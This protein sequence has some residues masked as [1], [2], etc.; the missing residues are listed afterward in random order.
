[1]KKIISVILTLAVL[2]GT[3]AVGSVA[4]SDTCIKLS[5]TSGSTGYSA[6]TGAVNTYA[7]KNG[8]ATL[9]FDVKL[10]SVATPPSGMT[11][12]LFAFSGASDYNYA[13]FD[14]TNGAFKAGEGTA[15]PTDSH[16]EGFTAY[17][18]RSFD[19]KVGQWYE[20]AYQFDGNNVTVYAD[21]MPM[22][23]AEVASSFETEYLILYP[24]YCTVL[25]DNLRVCSKDYNVRD[26]YGDVYA[27]TDFTGVTSA[28][29]A[30]CWSFEGTGYSVSTA[31][32]TMPELVD[33][34]PARTVSPEI[35]GS[36]LTYAEAGGSGA[37]STGVSFAAYNG[38]TVVEDIRVDRKSPLGNFSVR[39]GGNYIAGYDFDSARFLISQRSGYSFSSNSDYTYAEMPYTI[40]LKD[41]NE[42]AVRQYGETVSVYLNG[43]LMVQASNP[44]FAAGYDTVDVSCY[45]IGAA[46]DNMVVA[47]PDYNV[48]EAQ[49]SAAAKF[50]FDENTDYINGIWN[51]ALG[52][53]T[54]GYSIKRNADALT[55]VV[56]TVTADAG[57]ANMAISLAGC[58]GV[59]GFELSVTYP[60][61]ITVASVSTASRLTGS[62]AMSQTTANPLVMTYADVIGNTVTDGSVLNIVFNTP[63]EQ[64]NYTITAT[65]TPYFGDVPGAPVSASGK[66]TVPEPGLPTGYPDGVTYDGE[67]IS[68]NPV[69]GAIAY[70]VCFLYPYEDY[71]YPVDI[72]EDCEFPFYADEFIT[73]EG[74]SIIR[75]Y[76]YDETYER[77]GVSEDFKVLLNYDGTMHFGLKDYADN[78][79]NLLS[80]YVE[81][82]TYSADNL[83]TVN[84][85]LAEVKVAFDMASEFEEIDA[86][87]NE[88]KTL[89]ES[90]PTGGGVMFGDINGD[91]SVTATDAAL[92]T[93][94][95]SGAN[96]ELTSAADMN[97]DGSITSVDSALLSK[98][99]SGMDV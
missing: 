19:W 81:G 94:F 87:Y 24:Q 63:S 7:V 93:S 33:M 57:K 28:A 30:S 40:N 23:S 11:S 96:V 43:I 21:G 88:Y 39:F 18:T 92:L 68:W 2:M 4:A 55:P 85:Y 6:G 54:T 91:G 69:D 61:G 16:S 71:E 82:N 3:L 32:R 73:V 97:C 60:A 1:M 8:G 36:Y 86:A 62:S 76:Y 72:T 74:T 99:L 38:F 58:E 78:Y 31:G 14:F 22:V 13:G 27:A 84:G 9:I 56:P 5:D 12:R 20:I 48:K 44:A 29:A 75:I 59:S 95:L 89:I 46:I 64:G 83:E 52:K 90:V 79:Y 80:A 65:V 42:F 41:T 35:S 98:V 34:I 47:Y 51:F 66:I 45:R 70:E 50:S 25:I 49:G 53:G 77:A 26:R 10:E 15:W 67:I 17:S 37:A